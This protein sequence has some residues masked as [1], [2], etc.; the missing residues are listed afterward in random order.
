MKD[1]IEG[2]VLAISDYGEKSQIIRVITKDKGYLSFVFKSG[3]NA[4]KKNK[5]LP[6]SQYYF[7]C[8]YKEHKQLFTLH[9]RDLIKS[10]YASDLETMTFKQVF[11]EIIEKIKVDNSDEIYLNIIFVLSALN[12]DNKYLLGSFFIAR[13]LY[14]LGIT[15]YLKTCVNCKA[16][17]IV[18]FSNIKGGFVCRKH[19]TSQDIL[20]LISL[21][22]IRYIF[23][24]DK[25][26]VLKLQVQYEQ[27]DF[28]LL[29]TFL[30]TH[31]DIKLK[32]YDFYTSIFVS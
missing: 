8:D 2:L 18:G 23:L 26:N 32:A 22:K 24:V 9:N 4:N 16:L 6:L 1:K 15:P 7:Y 30:K 20:P 27:G 14:I 25:T 5:I 12:N 3:N 21:R 19:A 28:S 10:F 13:L 29:L 31:C 17:E 11:M